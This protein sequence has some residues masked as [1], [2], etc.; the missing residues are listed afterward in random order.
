[1]KLL[2]HCPFTKTGSH[3]QQVFSSSIPPN[4]LI[5]F[6]FYLEANQRDLGNYF[7]LAFLIL[8]VSLVE[9]TYFL[10]QVHL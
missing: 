4:A 2:H 9:Y 8:F 3:E 1:M 6:S 5:L 7:S 10:I